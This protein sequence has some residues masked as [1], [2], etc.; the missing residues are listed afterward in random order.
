[1]ND[2]KFKLFNPL[3]YMTDDSI[4]YIEDHTISK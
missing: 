1:M 2:N 4:Q 3:Y